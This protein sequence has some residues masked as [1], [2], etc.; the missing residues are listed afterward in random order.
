LV[1]PSPSASEVAVGEGLVRREGTVGKIGAVRVVNTV[2]KAGTV[3]TV[4]V[5]RRRLAGG[6]DAVVE[7]SLD[8]FQRQ[9]G[10]TLLAQYPTQAVDVRL[11]ELPVTR[12][13]P[14]GVHQ[15]LALEEA[16]LRDGDVGE[17]LLK[18]R[19][20]FAYR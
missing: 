14:F 13:G 16:D 3:R 11:V 4:A 5:R 1:G 8:H 15:P 17:L 6:L 9:K 12:R 18:E 2:G 19:Q 7:A 10:V 20:D